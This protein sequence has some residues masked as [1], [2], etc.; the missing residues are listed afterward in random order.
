P[1][2]SPLPQNLARDTMRLQS[3]LCPLSIMSTLQ[4]LVSPAGSKQYKPRSGF[5]HLAEFMLL[6]CAGTTT[7]RCITRLPR[8]RQP[9]SCRWW[10]SRARRGL[11]R[12]G[13][14]RTA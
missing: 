2:Q 11:T 10:I 1:S 9:A 7:F 8:K 6:L 12:R 5:I 14:P 4:D 3:S 13:P